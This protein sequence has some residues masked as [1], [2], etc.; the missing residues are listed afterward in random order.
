VSL[1]FLIFRLRFAFEIEKGE[2]E[3]KG[4]ESEREGQWIEKRERGL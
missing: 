3:G 2:R 4:E 1:L